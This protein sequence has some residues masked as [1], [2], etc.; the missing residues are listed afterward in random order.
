M[1]LDVD[2]FWSFRSPYSYIALHRVKRLVVEFD[3]EIRARPV[4][5][6]AVRSPDFFKR[7]DPLF[8][9]Y[10]RR[11]SVRVAEFADIPF[12]FPRPD[13]IV[14]DMKTLAIAAKQPYIRRLT[15]L[16]VAAQ[17]AGRGLAMIDAVGRLLWDGSV[18]NWHEGDHLANA[19]KRAGF[20]LPELEAAIAA[21]PA[22]YDTAI[23]ENQRDQRV[24]GHW[25]V[26]TFV[27][28]GEPFFGQ[29]RIDLLLWRLR[30]HGLKAR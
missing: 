21:H 12:R 4:Y 23:E 8:A 26:P 18:E 27:F 15:R 22:L 20:D 30:Q 16:G 3:L 13:P 28:R 9:K 5:P 14:Q 1:T 29:D 11:D 7:V 6:L 17:L 24:A 25:G 10:V 2:L 19:L